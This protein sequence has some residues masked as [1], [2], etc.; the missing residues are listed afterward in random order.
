MTNNNLLDAILTSYLWGQKLKLEKHPKYN[1]LSFRLVVKTHDPTA[2]EW[3]IEY[4]K[5]QLLDDGFLEIAK[6]EY[7]N[8]GQYEL[9]TSGIKAAKSRWYSKFSA[10][11][12]KED[13]IKENTLSNL[14]R[15]KYSLV[16]SIL[17]LIIPTII[18]IYTILIDNKQP[19]IDQIKELNK[20]IRKLEL[21][22]VNNKTSTLS[23]TIFSNLL[24]KNTNKELRM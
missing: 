14:K 10:D 21:D 19:I 24:K 1:R 7:G 2:D 20:R 18:S 22:K 5:K 11:K 8:E 9:T 16:I 4:L 3:Q 6:Y 13:E 12:Q 23:T 15:S 17:A